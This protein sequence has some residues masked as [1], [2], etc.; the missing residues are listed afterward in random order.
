MRMH[1]HNQRTPRWEKEEAQ[2]QTKLEEEAVTT[3]E[4]WTGQLPTQRGHHSRLLEQV[5]G[6]S[7]IP[8]CTPGIRAHMG[9]AIL[10]ATRSWKTVAGQVAHC[11]GWAL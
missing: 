5:L 4:A 9:G 1:N 2:V 6:R 3:Q 11:S 7:P 8:S 10:T